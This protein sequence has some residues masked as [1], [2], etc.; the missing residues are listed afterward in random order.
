MKFTS[1]QSRRRRYCVFHKSCQPQL[2]FQVN[3]T[4]SPLFVSLISF[5][6]PEL[7][8]RN[9]KDYSAS[10]TAAARRAAR[11][12]SV[13]TNSP[14]GAH[15]EPSYTSAQVL[16]PERN[17]ETSTMVGWM[18]RSTGSTP[19]RRGAER[20]W[21]RAGEE[22]DIRCAEYMSGDRGVGQGFFFLSLLLWSPLPSDS[23]PAS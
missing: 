8:S 18:C 4:I 20:E 9:S 14:L 15:G 5:R 10:L 1:P 7:V 21:Q 19:G 12:S 16:R 23:L 6:R 17:P 3:L 2:P 11:W 22:A 13:A